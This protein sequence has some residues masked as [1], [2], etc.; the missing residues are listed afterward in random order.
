MNCAEEVDDF[1]PL[2]YNEAVH[3]SNVVEWQQAMDDE[4]KSLLK[5][6]TWTLVE[7]PLSQ[8]IIQCKWIYKLKPGIDA[9]AKPRFKARL[10][11][12]GYTQKEGV[13][14]NE[15][16]SPVVRHSSIRV[17]LSLATQYGP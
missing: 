9:N 3:S 12:K 13:D 14:F 7:R 10:V 6:N 1:E 16:F 17:I 2:S 15:V 5:N 8:K 11:A 4:L